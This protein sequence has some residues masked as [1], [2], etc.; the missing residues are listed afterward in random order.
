MLGSEQLLFLFCQR[1]EDRHSPDKTDHLYQN[2][3][4]ADADAVD[5]YVPLRRAAARHKGLVV[6][7]QGCE[8]HAEAACQKQKPD[9]AYAVYIQRKGHGYRQQKV[10]GHMSQLPHRM[11]DSL[12]ILRLLLRA[13]VQIKAL[14]SRLDNDFTYLVA[15][16]PRGRSILGGK[17]EDQIHHQKSRDEG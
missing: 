14:I 3:T 15:Q 6:F 4:D 13:P 17:A 12:D 1:P 7:V 5:G 10:F 8:A 11:M 2:H 16:I 9:T